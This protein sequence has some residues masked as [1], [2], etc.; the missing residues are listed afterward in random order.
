MGGPGLPPP[1]ELLPLLLLLLRLS[2][3]SAVL[4]VR[5]L[6]VGDRAVGQGVRGAAP[7]LTHLPG[8]PAEELAEAEE[9]EAGESPARGAER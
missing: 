5:R 2:L 4:R 6:R 7:P 1:S 9:A 8:A 3:V